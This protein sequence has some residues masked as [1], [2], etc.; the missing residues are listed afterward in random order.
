[1]CFKHKSQFIPILV[2]TIGP[3]IHYGERKPVDASRIVTFKIF[4][5][6][7]RIVETPYI[8]RSPIWIGQFILLS[9]ISGVDARAF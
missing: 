2:S 7:M 5:V 9:R 6:I 8:G 1:M 4:L 3:V